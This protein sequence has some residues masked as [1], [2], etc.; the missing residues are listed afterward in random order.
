MRDTSLLIPM[1]L[2]LISRHFTTETIIFTEKKAEAHK[3]HVI[4]GL[5]GIK[6][7]E[8]HGNLN[9]TQRLRALDRFAKKEVDFLIA[10]D[11]AARGLDVKVETGKSCQLGS[12]NS[13]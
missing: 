5:L 13:Y 8:L 2:S 1:L 11:V 4:L 6:S 3:L 9:Q 12:A 7:A 10:T